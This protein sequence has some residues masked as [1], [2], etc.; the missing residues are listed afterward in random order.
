RPD[1]LRSVLERI[2]NQ[3]SPSAVRTWPAWAPGWIT[4]VLAVSAFLFGGF[5][6]VMALGAPDTESLESPLMLSVPR[7]L[8]AGPWDLYGPFGGQNPLVLIHA[9]L[10]SRLAAIA[11]WPLHMA[12]LDPVT[13]ARLA[14]RSLS[15]LGLVA[16]LVVLFQLTCIDG[17]PRR[18]GWW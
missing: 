11:A 12:G 7:P 6:L 16:T 4:L 17:A 3:V 5:R 18:A 15:L 2:V 14:G 1:R 13:A 8:V 9:P 10:Y